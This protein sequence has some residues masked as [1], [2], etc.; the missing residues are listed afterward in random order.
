MKISDTLSRLP[1]HCTEWEEDAQTNYFNTSDIL[2]I[3]N[4]KIEQFILID[5][6]LKYIFNFIAS[7]WPVNI[8]VKPY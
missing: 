1:L 7:G 4:K 2:P 8:L 5:S 6:K 3:T